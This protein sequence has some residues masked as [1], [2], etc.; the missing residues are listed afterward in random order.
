VLLATGTF[1]GETASGWQQL[2]LPSAVPITANTTYVVSYH[3]PNGHYTGTD[4]G[5]ASAGVDNAPLHGLK[6]GVDGAN[7]VYIYGST[8][9]F[10]TNTSQGE[11]YWTDVVFSTTPPVDTTPPT[12]ASTSPAANVLSVDPN[13]AL[14]ATF[15]EAMDPTTISSSTAGEGGGSS[16]GTFELRDPANNLV[17]SVVTYDST[18][19]TAKLQP[20]AALLVSTRYTATLKG[21]TADPRA[22]DIAGNALAVSFSWSFTTAAAPPPPPTCKV[23]RD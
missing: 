2:N 1:S 10:P 13:A 22:K 14:T 21:G 7:G 15:S 17:G 20:N 18:T 3:A 23:M 4:S 11:N 12:V 16:F 9:A 8:S 6:T 5:F 19:R